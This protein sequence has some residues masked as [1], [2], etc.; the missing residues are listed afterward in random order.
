MTRDELERALRS[1]VDPYERA[2][3]A[4]PLPASVEE[5]RSRL[6]VRH[7]TGWRAL[8]FAGATVAAALVI[9]AAVAGYGLVTGGRDT[10]GG[11]PQ[12]S[13]ASNVPTSS[14]AASP[15]E[16]ARPCRAADF[17]IT[18]DAWDAGA[19]SRGTRVIFRAADSLDACVLAGRLAA[20]IVDS[21]GTV[22]VAADSDAT[23]AMSVTGGG[24]L[25]IGVAWS[26][27]CGEDPTQPLELRVRFP[28]DAVEVA[29]VPPVGSS[30]LVPPC[31]GGGQGTTLSV[32]GFEPSNRPPPEG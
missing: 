32:T 10:G 21:E 23:P 25:E 7:A 19:G 18:S 17:A 20:R 12:A 1:T 26:N 29:L 16:T 6:G 11:G 24:Q 4:V 9:V 28:E 30:I 8:R 15:S 14:P 3:R 13:V 27:W 22:L 31:M 2:Y 5:A